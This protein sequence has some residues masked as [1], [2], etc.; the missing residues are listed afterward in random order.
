MVLYA[1]SLG[2]SATVLGIL[3]GMMPLLV[4]AQLPAVKFLNRIGFRRFVMAGWS[5]RVALIFVVTVVP[6]TSGFLDATTRLVLVLALLFAFNVSRG[7]AGA[8]WLPWITELVPSSLRGRHFA[9]DQ[10][11]VNGGSVVAFA[12][13]G[14]LLGQNGTPGRFALVFL[15]A[16]IA[17]AISLPLLSRIPDA[18]PQPEADGG[19]GPVPWLELSAYPPFRRLLYVNATWSLAYGGLTTFV[20]KYLKDGADMHGDKILYFMS[21]S[22]LGGL[23]APWLAGVRMDRLGSKPLLSFTMVLGF[24]IG[25]GWWLAASGIVAPGW[26]LSLPLMLLLGLINALFSAANNRLAMHLVPAFGR[27]HFFALFMVVWQ[28]TL[29]LSP[30]FWGLLLDVIGP[31]EFSALGLIWNRYS[32]YFALVAG[33][34]AGAFAC[35]RRLEEPTAAEIHE[36]VRELLIIEPRRWWTFFSGR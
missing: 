15:L 18:T 20:V 30:I 17:G 28:V 34:F 23:A 7:I 11:Y 25:A 5:T 33:A 14:L 19:K 16:G 21:I 29:G 3:A 26:S 35:C 1:K 36:L 9:R 13:C 27:N 10:F 12:G 6:L 31:W 22:F 2:A 8:A 32:I 4:I 24:I